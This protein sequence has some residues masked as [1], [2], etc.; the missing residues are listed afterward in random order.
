MAKVLDGDH[1]GL[2]SSCLL[3]QKAMIN[4]IDVSKY[5][6]LILTHLE[7]LIPLTSFDHFN[8]IYNKKEGFDYS[9]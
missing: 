5:V 4:V 3:V 7:F 6:L 9:N 1:V 2:Q 8:D